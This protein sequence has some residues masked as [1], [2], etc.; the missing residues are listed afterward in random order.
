MDHK[1]MKYQIKKNKRKKEK[2][3]ILK[4]DVIKILNQFIKEK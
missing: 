3:S 2:Y 4:L 1:T